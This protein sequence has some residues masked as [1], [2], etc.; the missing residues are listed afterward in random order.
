M[1]DTPRFTFLPAS[2]HADMAWR[3][4]LG[5]TAEIARHPASGDAFDWRLSIATIGADGPFSAFP[6]CDRTLVP[7][8]GGGLALDFAD[9]RTLSGGL[10]EPIRFAGDEPCH[11]RLLGAVRT[12]DLNAITRRDAASHD[13]AIVGATQ[14]IDHAEGILFVVALSGAI[15]V[16]SGAM[17]WNLAQG[18]ALRVDGGCEALAIAEARPIARAAIVKI[19]LRG[20]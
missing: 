2:G 6:G 3:N 14:R 17:A 18:D 11:G 16:S 9:G 10:F 8:E 5:R 20:A 19:S 1:Q 12:R 4:G 7:I 13:V 15:A